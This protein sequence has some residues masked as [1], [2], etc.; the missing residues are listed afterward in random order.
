MPVLVMCQDAHNAAELRDRYQKAHN[1]YID[2]VLA[3]VCVTG[4]MCQSPQA[5]EDNTQEG[6][7][8]IFDTDDLAVARKL[9]KY[10]PFAQAG[11]YSEVA[12]V[13]FNP[14]AGYW[15]TGVPG[16]QPQPS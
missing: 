3:L 8:F 5:I 6:T 13:K 2:T 16:V 7:C 10:D 11:V 9:M 1:E 15:I 14:S 12:F 4:A